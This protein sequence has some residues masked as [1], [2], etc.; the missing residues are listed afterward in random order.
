MKKI[1]LFLIILIFII[2]TSIIGI[3]IVSSKE[4]VLKKEDTITLQSLKEEQF[5]C[6]GYDI[7][8]PN[9]ILDPFDISPLTAIIIFETDKRE[10]FTIKIDGKNN[11]DIIYK[12][13]NLTKYHFI[14]IYGLYSDYENI[15]H[16]STASVDKEIKIKTEKIEFSKLP[17]NYINENDKI[18]L[19]STNNGV[20]GIDKHGEIRYYLKGNYN[21]E[22]EI[23]DNN[24]LLLST[25]RVNNENKNTGIVEISLL[26]KIYNEY[27]LKDGYYGLIYNIDETKTL[28]LSKNIIIY[29]RQTGKEVKKI[30]LNNIEDK[31]YNLSYNKDTEEVV[32]KGEYVEIHYDYNDCKIKKIIGDKN[33][34]PNNLL[35]YV[36][37]QKNDKLDTMIDNNVLDDANLIVYDVKQ[38]S[39]NKDVFYDKS[40]GLI[41]LGNN[42]TKESS[43]NINTLF[44]K[45]FNDEVKMYQEYDRLVVEGNFNP[46][47]KVYIILDKF[48]GKK[49]YDFNTK[50][51]IKYINSFGLNG[52]YNIY[53]KINEKLLKVNKYVY[54]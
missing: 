5:D 20:I 17:T 44:Y 15:I 51:N 36:T 22:I 12:E 53:I 8:N 21:K 25:N 26:G 41:T 40:K 45:K 11:D 34:V 46:E 32:I 13:K 33:I 6:Y 2:C 38:I 24:N 35:K 43:K 31:W 52:K 9:V 27:N 29:D 7:N 54:F 18:N 49:V 48:M 28:V 30:D 1:Y 42:K 3:F 10:Q 47:D 50:T 4:E 39:F 14:P 19:I 37:E 16:L 23:L